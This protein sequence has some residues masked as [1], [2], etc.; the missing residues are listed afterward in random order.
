MAAKAS[1]PRAKELRGV[2][3]EAARV[4]LATVGA[5]VKFWARWAESAERYT[6]A[7]DDELGKVTSDVSSSDAVA[8]LADVSRAYLRELTDLPKAT[9]EEFV[10]DLEKAAPRPAP[11]KRKRSARAKN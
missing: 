6:R 10:R 7:L 4:Q 8:R 11:G 3:V 2:L 9:L 1:D 5:A